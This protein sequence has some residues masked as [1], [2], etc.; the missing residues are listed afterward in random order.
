[1]KDKDRYSQQLDLQ[2]VR[3]KELRKTYIAMVLKAH[4][5]SQDV[6]ESVYEEGFEKQWPY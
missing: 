2:G 5:I 4:G 1:M 6:L 3:A